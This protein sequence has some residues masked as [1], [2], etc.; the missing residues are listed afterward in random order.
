VAEDNMVNQ[1]LALQLLRRMGYR[2]DI[3]ANGL[4]VLEALQRQPYD[5]V[6]MDVHMPEMD[7][8]SATRQICQQR[9][10][11]ERP[12]IVAM[13]ANAMRGDREKCLRAGMDDYISKPIRVDEL[14][15]ALNHCLPQEHPV[16]PVLA[17][18]SAIDA[19]VLQ[20]FREA[21]GDAASECLAQLIK[22]FLEETPNLVQGIATA[23]AQGD[24]TA[25]QSSA[26]ALKS[27]SASLGAMT[28]SQYCQ[29]LE[30]MGCSGTLATASEVASQLKEEYERVER[31]LREEVSLPS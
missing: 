24:A 16:E 6:F 20:A 28:L 12:R 15:R 25:L 19:E 23:A 7:G 30:A 5:V 22:I 21:M 10:P 17:R 9:S 1:Q 29:T 18:Q 27:S 8:L 26:H 11:A 14:V 2:A 31:E 13:T 3:A 4:E